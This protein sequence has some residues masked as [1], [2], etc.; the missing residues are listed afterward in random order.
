MLVKEIIYAALDL[1]K[2][3][4]SDDSF[5]TEEHVLFLLK[6]YRNFLIKKE[7]DKDK[8]SSDTPTEFECTQQICLDLEE[9]QEIDGQPCTGR[10][11]MKSVRQVPRLLDGFQPKIY[12]ANFYYGTNIAFVNRDRMRFVGTNKYLQNI[13]YVSYGPDQFLYLTSDN[14]QFTNLGKVKMSAVFEDFEEALDYLCDDD[15]CPIICDVMDAE[16]PIKG[17][18]VPS[19]LELVVKELVGAEYRPSEQLNNAND[20]L[21]DLVA[22]IRRNAKTALQKQIEG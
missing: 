22:F 9:L 12:P 19:L 14:P 5:F 16:F 20:D 10:P 18:L 4:T 2:A 17:D 13:I 8:S 6:K 11:Y 15:A 7:H 3:A 1:A 21:S